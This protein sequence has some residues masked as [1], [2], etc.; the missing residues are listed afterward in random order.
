M[1]AVTECWTKRRICNLCAPFV[2]KC[3]PLDD[4]DDGGDDCCWLSLNRCYMGFLRD[5]GDVPRRR[6]KNCVSFCYTGLQHD[7]LSLFRIFICS[8][9]LVC[10]LPQRHQP[11]ADCGQSAK[12]ASLRTVSIKDAASTRRALGSWF[13]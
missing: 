2:P 5:Q 4:G 11:P 9:L 8:F 7:K 6:K 12:E 3:A 13:I 10:S 1:E